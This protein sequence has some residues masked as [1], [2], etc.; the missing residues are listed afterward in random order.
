[1]SD[2][3]KEIISA[4]LKILRAEKKIT[5]RQLASN[6][7]LSYRSIVDYENKN[8]EPNSKAMVALEQFF[9]VSGAYLRGETDEREP[10]QQWEDP[11]MA[12][13]VESELWPAFKGVLKA[14]QDSTPQIQKLVFDIMVE[15][16]HVLTSP[17][18]TPAQQESAMLLLQNSFRLCTQYTDACVTAQPKEDMDAQEQQQL[19]I[20][21]LDDMREEILEKYDSALDAAGTSI[22]GI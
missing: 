22:A 4:R 15:M 21:R 7:G 17:S 19:V 6:T 12:A 10:M 18:Y 11:A 8:R 13:V 14:T 9:N 3:T 20:P 2:K 16:R 1:M 5:Q